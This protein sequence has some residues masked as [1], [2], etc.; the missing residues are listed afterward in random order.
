M[1]LRNKEQ[2]VQTA[3]TL[4]LLSCSRSSKAQTQ[5]PVNDGCLWGGRGMKSTH[6][7]RRSECGIFKPHYF[8]PHVLMSSLRFLPGFFRLSCI[9]LS[10]FR[11]GWDQYTFLF[12]FLIILKVH[13][14][15]H[16]PLFTVLQKNVRSVAVIGKDVWMEW[17]GQNNEMTGCSYKRGCMNDVCIR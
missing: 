17:P 3:I 4:S 11:E 9:F 13:F 12:R 7:C 5:A 10:L 2:N 8:N 14:H 16:Y 1:Y 6:L 15:S